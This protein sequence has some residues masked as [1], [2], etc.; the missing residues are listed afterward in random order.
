MEKGLHIEQSVQRVKI[1]GRQYSKTG[2]PKRFIYQDPFVYIS[3]K[4]MISTST[5]GTKS[6]S[7]FYS[8]VCLECISS[9]QSPQ[10]MFSEDI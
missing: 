10:I 5:N 7:S 3:L 4:C 9:V 1:H 6:F 2:W 8:N